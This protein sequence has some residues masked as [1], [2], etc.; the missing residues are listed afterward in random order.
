MSAAH[1]I[2]SKSK[3]FESVQLKLKWELSLDLP[4]NWAARLMLE[5][6]KIIYVMCL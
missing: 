3:E 5:I 4:W 6:E 2:F 1:E